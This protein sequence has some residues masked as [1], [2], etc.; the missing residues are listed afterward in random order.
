MRCV[1]ITRI[2]GQDGSYPPE[3][4]VSKGYEAHG[5][6]H[7]ASTVNTHGVDYLFRDLDE[8][9]EPINGLSGTRC[10]RIGGGSEGNAGS[11]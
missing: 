3:L 9:G 7:R 1:L 2:T 10:T 6:I 5:V 11:G 8:P 4:L